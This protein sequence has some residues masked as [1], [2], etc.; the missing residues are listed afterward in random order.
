ML[1]K[2]ALLYHIQCP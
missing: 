1:T 2:Y